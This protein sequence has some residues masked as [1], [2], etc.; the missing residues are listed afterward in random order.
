M[1]PLAS[2]CW[3]WVMAVPA[4]QMLYEIVD[5]LLMLVRQISMSH[6]IPSIGLIFICWKEPLGKF[7][8]L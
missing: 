7:L 8:M 5:L 2:T 3:K 1:A 4:V 6:K